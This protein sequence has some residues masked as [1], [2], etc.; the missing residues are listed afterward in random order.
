[1]SK[2][3]AIKISVYLGAFVLANFVVLWFGAT[4]LIFTAL[5]LIPF[6]FVMR[7]VFHETWKGWELI[8]R[9]FLL[10]LSA[11]VLSYIINIDTKMIAIA[12]VIGYTSAQIVAGAFY[13]ILIQKSYFTKVNGSDALG[14]LVDSMCFQMY[15][16]SSISWSVMS[17]QF[18]LKIIGG[19][20]WYYIIFKK[21][22]LHEKWLYK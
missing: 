8:W 11:G 20:F 14:I 16:F 7:C 10:V 1:M 21:L 3:L 13:Q 5:F 6:D 18:I 2:L 22:K 12:S 9:M 4:G 17:S 19:L 15:A